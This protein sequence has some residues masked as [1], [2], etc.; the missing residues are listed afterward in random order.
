MS[1]GGST[2]TTNE[3][4]INASLADSG[5]VANAGAN[6]LY[7]QGTAGI[8]QGTRLADQDA[9]IMQA[10]EEQLRLAG[11]DGS[12]R[13]M[14]NQQQQAFSG[15]LGAG[16]INNALTQRQIGDLADTVGENFNR[17]I[18]PS[19]NQGAT[20]AGQ[21]GSSR[22]GVAQGIAAGD[23]ANAISRGATQALLGGQNIAMQAQG[24]AANS[25]G[26]GLLPSQIQQD[27][28]QQRTNLSQNQLNDN[29]QQFN[30]PRQAELQNLQQFNQLLGSNPLMGESTQTQ[31][32]KKSGGTGQAL[33]GTAITL[34]S[35]YMTG[36]GS[37][38]LPSIGGG[39]DQQP[40]QTFG[41]GGQ[42]PT[43][44]SGSF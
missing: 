44:I 41:Y 14:V 6:T 39:G 25:I 33:L 13:N 3:T 26:L 15:L 1:G 42:S 20:G 35:A 38:A 12:L 2:T 36:G 27:V 30:A 21:F 28:G 8:Y 7:N 17:V 18:M 11:Q 22:Q 16:D 43:A 31:T 34:G 5:R 4:K 10:Q 37:L 9:N 32:Q 19:I 40:M 23:A 29:I 24:N